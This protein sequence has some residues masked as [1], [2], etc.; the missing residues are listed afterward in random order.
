MTESAA[1]VAF[2]HWTHTLKTGEADYAKECMI[3]FRMAVEFGTLYE[4]DLEEELPAL[5]YTVTVRQ[6]YMI[7]QTC[8][9]FAIGL[10]KEK[11]GS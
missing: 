3:V 1:E 9:D 8:F 10:K 2:Q 4:I 11:D 7:R 6:G 5:P